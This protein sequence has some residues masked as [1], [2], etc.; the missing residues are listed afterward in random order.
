MNNNFEK[1]GICS[2]ILKSL[3]FLNL[4]IPTPIQEKVIPHILKG[5]NV[6]IK[7]P[8]GTG[9]T[10]SFVIPLL[11]M[12]KDNKKIGKPFIL[13]IS[14][15]R[16]LT[17]QIS[18]NFK[19]ISKYLRFQIA[20]FVGGI[21]EKNQIQK[22]NKGLDVVV[23]TP[24]RLCDFIRNKKIDLSNV[25]HFVLDEV[26]L[27]LDMGFI[28]D[29]N[30]I[31]ENLNKKNLQTIFLS[32][33]I[34]NSIEILAS[35][36]LKKYVKE[37]VNIE[38]KQK[39]LVKQT[40]FFVNKN[41]KKN[42][43]LQ[44]I[45]KYPNDT[46]IIFTNYK[47]RADEIS[48]FLYA[49]QIKC[50]SFHGDKN[51]FLRQKS[52]NDFKSKV[53]KILVATDVAARGIHV[54]NVN[55][56]INFDIPTNSDVYIHRMGRTGRANNLGEC[57]SIC[58]QRD[59]PFMQEILKHQKNKIKVFLNENNDYK[60]IVFH[61]FFDKKWLI[62]KDNRISKK[63]SQAINKNKKYTYKVNQ[64]KGIILSEHFADET[65]KWKENF[66]HKSKKFKNQKRK[67]F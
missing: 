56:V 34:P 6:L 51:Q 60:N 8:T 44:M 24:G 23:S 40:V 16:E 41:N 52:I 26:D 18:D 38:T 28:K 2:E 12:N 20:S 66:K 21:S 55:F 47:K 67:K 1:F 19:N 46:F 5:K 9:K 58:E 11:E 61:N 57:F 35:K 45:N 43:L 25:S 39:P 30:F 14:P 62:E 49:N 29:I 42:L 36:M 15:T 59:L 53:I 7:A 65:R 3:N 27:I 31:Y 17:I 48:K 4:I 10:A 63:N 32:A 22:I 54:D 13:V 50:K 64:Q 37:E 33:T